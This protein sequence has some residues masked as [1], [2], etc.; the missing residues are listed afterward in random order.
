MPFSPNLRSNKKKPGGQSYGGGGYRE[1]SVCDLKVS[2]KPGLSNE[3]LAHL[4]TRLATAILDQ[5]LQTAEVIEITDISDRLK[6]RTRNES[7]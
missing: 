2:E 5:F 6:D 7:T 3:Y 4:A 1:V